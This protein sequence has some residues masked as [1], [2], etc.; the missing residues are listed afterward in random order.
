MWLV[1]LADLAL[2]LVGFFV[3]IQ[4]NQQITNQALA[5]GLRE[6]F[7]VTTRLAAPMPVAIGS[8]GEFA[9]GSSALPKSPASLSQWA[10]SV[11]ADPR[12][13][14]RISGAVDGSPADVEPVTGSSAVLAADRARAVAVALA[15]AGAVPA[16]RMT[17]TTDP[18]PGRR[19]VML[20]LGF[21]GERP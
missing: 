15:E 17:I 3:L 2:L 11:T 18:I 10:R 6:G 14:L 5:K 20:T 1:T 13:R 7:G 8:M 4:A 12:V 9:P 16:A 19:A 21:D